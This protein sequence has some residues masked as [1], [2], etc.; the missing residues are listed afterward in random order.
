MLVSYPS[1][2]VDLLLEPLLRQLSV[3][4][5]KSYILNMFDF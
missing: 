3:S 1:I 4:E 5:G 2:P